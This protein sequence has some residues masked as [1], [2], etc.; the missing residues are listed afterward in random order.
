MNLIRYAAVAG[1]LGLTVGAATLVLSVDT[2]TGAGAANGVAITNVAVVAVESGRVH[3]GHTVVIA[4]DRIVAVGS[5]AETRVPAGARL[6]DGTGRYLIPGLWDMHTHVTMV[7][8][9]ALDLLLAQGVT[10]ARD[11]GAERFADARAL[12]DS[13]A[14]GQRLGPRLKI[15]SPVVE[16]P[17]WLAAVR[18]MVDASGTPWRLYERFG[19]AT[20]EAAVAWVD[21]VARLGADHIKVRNWPAA[22][23][24]RAL[25]GRAAAHGLPVVAHPNRPFPA[26]GL[27]TLEHGVWPPIAAEAE[28]ATL[29]QTLAAEGTAFVPTLVTTRAVRFAPPDTLLARLDRGDIAGLRYVPAEARREWRDQLL[30][31]AQETG[32]VDYRQIYRD[33]LRDLAEM[34]RAGILIL[35]G[36]DVGAPLVVPGLSLHEELELLVRDA[37][38][39]PL[40]ALRAATLLPARVLGLADAGT[41]AP[42]QLADLVLLDGNPL[43]EIGATRRIHAVVTAGRLLDRAALDRLL[44]GAGSGLDLAPAS[45][46]GPASS[47]STR[48]AERGRNTIEGADR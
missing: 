12:R 8:G 33:G 5:A 40:E 41:I 7:G 47:P 3:P 4:G 24:A 16:N 10:G 25:V 36:S 31:L 38:L 1:A 46:P 21:S 23:V 39:S 17:G 13:I 27:A 42:G 26:R 9:A 6:V 14:A 29:W 22:A 2:D 37:G 48:R 28:R 35:A 34:R 19:P 15:A 45:P 18:Q 20:P 11:M 44:A 30:Q 43:A 32:T